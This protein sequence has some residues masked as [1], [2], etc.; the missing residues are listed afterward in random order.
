MATYAEAIAAV[1]AGQQ[2]WRPTAGPWVASSLI[3][4]SAAGSVVDQSGNAYSGSAADKAATDW[5]TGA[6]KPV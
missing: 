3:K 5:T 6:S 1:N 4:K 2:A